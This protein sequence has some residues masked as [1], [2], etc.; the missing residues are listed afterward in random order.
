MALSQ[1][2]GL[3][4]R[5]MAGWTLAGAR[6]VR[7]PHLVQY[8]QHRDAQDHSPEPPIWKTAGGHE[9]FWK[10]MSVWGKALNHLLFNPLL[11]L[12]FSSC[13]PICSRLP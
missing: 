3:A 12:R 9:Y 8:P 1:R 5:T 13:P 11:S 6:V 2:F 4:G 10:R 7:R